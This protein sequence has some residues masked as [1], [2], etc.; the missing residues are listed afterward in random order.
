MQRTSY[1]HVS[2]SGGQVP[3]S[4]PIGLLPLAGGKQLLRPVYVSPSSDFLKSSRSCNGI[5]VP[6]VEFEA[7]AAAAAVVI[8]VVVVDVEI[9]VAPAAAVVVVADV[10]V[11]APALSWPPYAAFSAAFKLKLLPLDVT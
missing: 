9:V 6:L 3:Y 7:A 1:P 10:V 11:V 5:E 2:W 4:P 8:A